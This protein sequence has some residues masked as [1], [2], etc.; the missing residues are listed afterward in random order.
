LVELKYDFSLNV[1]AE[2]YFLGTG[3]WVATPQRDNTS[4]L[5]RAG[6]KLALVDCPGSV[7]AKIRKLDFD[8]REVSTVFLTHVHP[9]HIYGLPSLVHSLILEDGEIRLF[10]SEETV[11]FARR[12][13][14]L[15]GL[16]EKNVKTRVRFRVVRPG[17]GL[18][19]HGSL[20]VRAFRVPHHSSSLAY[21]FFLD[22]GKSQLVISGDTPVHLPL[23][24]D[25]RSID[26]LVHEASAPSRYF[27]KYPRLYAIHTS[28]LDL[29]RRSQ[30]AGVKCLIPCHFL[31]DVWSDP[32]EVRAEIRRNFKNRL[33]VPRDLQ[34][35][36]V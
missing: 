14:D 29:G 7:V 22:Q 5:L 8:P 11:G 2:I 17:Q 16:L 9:D 26:Y 35:I 4:F 24:E 18:R 3:G 10:G 30:E 32:S 19:L 31:A 20:S 25:A 36:S 15:F 34:R 1:M 23:F 13:L 12:L 21:H 27:K 6:G 33:I 28:A